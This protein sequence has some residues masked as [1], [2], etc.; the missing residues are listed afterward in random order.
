MR[1]PWERNSK[2]YRKEQ[3]KIVT[4]KGQKY[5]SKYQQK[6]LDLKTRKTELTRHEKYSEIG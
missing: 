2:Q 1:E 3:M 4:V 6:N 5:N